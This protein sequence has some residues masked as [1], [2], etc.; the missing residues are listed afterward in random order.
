MLAAIANAIYDATGIRFKE[1]PITPEKVLEALSP[2]PF[3]LPSG[4]RVG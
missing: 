1:L 4:E 3:P 2:H